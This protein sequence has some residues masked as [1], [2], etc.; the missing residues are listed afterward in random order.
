MHIVFTGPESSGKTTLADW[1]SKKFH[2]PLVR[3]MARIYLESRP[4]YDLQDLS[5]ILE[6]QCLEERKLS[7]NKWLI[8]DTDALTIEIWGKYKFDA[9]LP[10]L[11]DRNAFGQS[12]KYYFLCDYDIPWVYDPLREHPNERHA[13][14]QMYLEYLQKYKFPFCQLSGPLQQR[15]AM[16]IDKLDALGLT[17]SGR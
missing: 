14:F 2:L 16:I 1:T 13:I 10:E 8:C 3:E 11:K 5:R 9:F 6:L 4:S 7:V 17:D 12:E 15:Q